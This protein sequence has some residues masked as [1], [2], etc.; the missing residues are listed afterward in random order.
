MRTKKDI[1]S[2]FSK[3]SIFNVN[4]KDN[5]PGIVDIEIKGLWYV[6]RKQKQYIERNKPMGIIF[7]ISIYSPILNRRIQSLS[8]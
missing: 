7:N 2:Y 1:K 8:I 3:K 4:I 5:K 6:T